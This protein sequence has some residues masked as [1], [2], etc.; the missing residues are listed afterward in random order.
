MLA[1]GYRVL[2]QGRA[3]Q[4]GKTPLHAAA[5]Q[6]RLEVARLLLEAGADVT[7]K[8]MVSGRSV[9]DG[10]R[11]IRKRRYFGEGWQPF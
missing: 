2:T 6:G 3:M 11:G 9:G 7:A 10:A 4:M 8:D 5:H 1:G